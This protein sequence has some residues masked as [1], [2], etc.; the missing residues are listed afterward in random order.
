MARLGNALIG[1]MQDLSRIDTKD[2]ALVRVNDSLADP[3]TFNALFEYF[4]VGT[5]LERIDLKVEPLPTQMKCACG[6]EEVVENDHNGYQNCPE[7]GRFA[8]I[9]D[10][11]YKLVSPNPEKAKACN[12]IRF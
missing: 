5:P 4:S 3:E 9:E 12:S 6:R 7:C 1:L 10:E 11:P 8:E 2:E